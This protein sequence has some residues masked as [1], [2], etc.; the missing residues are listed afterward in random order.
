MKISSFNIQ[1][2]YW[3]LFGVILY[4]ILLDLNYVVIISNIYTY[5]GFG[6]DVTVLSYLISWIILLIP[7]RFILNQYSSKYILFAN[8][9]TLLYLMAFVPGTSIMAFMPMKP[10]F[11]ILWTTYWYLIFIFSYSLKPFKPLVLSEKLKNILLYTILAIFI[12]TI[13]YVSWKYTA[14]RIH[15]SL[16]DINDIRL[17]AREWNVPTIL[18]YLL[19]AAGNI[20]PLLFVYFLFQKKK[21][22]AIITAIIIILNFSIEGQK[23]I[24]FNLFIC[25]LG[26][27]L[28]NEKRITLFSWGLSLVSFS[29]LLQ[30]LLAGKY[31][32]L[33]V[34]VRRVLY[35]PV[36]LNYHYYNFFSTHNFDYFR[37]SFLRHFGFASPYQTPIPRLIGKIY[38]NDP[39]NNANNGLFSDAYLNLGTVGV[40]VFPFVLVILFKV[41]DAASRAVNVKLLIFPVVITVFILISGTLTS[42]LLTNGILLLFVC[43][44]ALPKKY[45]S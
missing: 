25:L 31:N 40:L 12:L 4:R 9:I 38:Y 13:I 2:F 26:Y 18:S 39:T 19:A 3:G 29:A 32:I 5:Q 27:W 21:K 45:N 8:V 15:R 41:M 10:T 28:Y 6:N 14:F 22:L 11:S 16:S 37:Q 36:F 35:V 7:V 44:L 42:G 34:I 24:M 20:L 43:L 23:V 1:G 30:Y 33:D 17:E